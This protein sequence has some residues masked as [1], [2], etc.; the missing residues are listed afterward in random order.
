MIIQVVR[1]YFLATAAFVSLSMAGAAQE[2]PAAPVPSQ[3]PASMP[4]KAFPSLFGAASAFPAAGNTGFIALTYGNPRGGASGAGGDGDLG[5]GYTFGSP[6]KNLS[7]TA[8]VNITGLEPLGDSGSVFFSV[9]RALSLGEKHATFIG[10]SAGNL[11]AWGDANQLPE[12]YSVYVSHLTS[13]P[14]AAE[15]PVQFTL[16]Y[17]NQTTLSA[18]N[19]GSVDDGAFMGVGFGVFKNLAVSMS[20]TKTTVNLGAT[21]IVPGAERLSVTAGFYD[22]SANAQ[23]QQFVLTAAY[24]F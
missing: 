15:L 1:A 5:F 19:I 21:A 9:A 22:V 14:G 18:T 16:G 20:F 2:A 6:I 11:A 12:S 10:A 24:S 13:M 3:V 17:G 8:G 23:R 7:L 4:V